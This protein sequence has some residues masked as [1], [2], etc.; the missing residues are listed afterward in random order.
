MHSDSAE[1]KLLKLIKGSS[2]VKQ[3]QKQESLPLPSPDLAKG[4]GASAGQKAGKPFA[5]T[6]ISRWFKGLSLEA[7]N[8]I[9]RL[10]LI[11]IFLLFIINYFYGAKNIKNFLKEDSDPQDNSDIASLPRPLGGE[12]ID[13]S[14]ALEKRDI[15]TASGAPVLG[16]SRANSNSSFANAI[17]SLK[18]LGVIAGN[19]P[20]AIIE[21]SIEQKSY[22]V[23][24]G[25]YFKELLVEDIGS[26]KVTFS[27]KGARFEL[28]L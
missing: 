16:Q 4:L 19:E 13:Y 17:A 26:G 11:A 25:D 20:Q 8:K 7:I 21:D 15:F 27:Y 24:V 9:L 6:N 28:F 5:F 3:R 22:T 2:G 14:A 10:C 23:G 18:L 12:L 1:E